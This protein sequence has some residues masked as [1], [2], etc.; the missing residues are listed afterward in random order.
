MESEETETGEPFERV[1]EAYDQLLVPALFGQWA[2]LVA[3]VAGVR[4]GDRVLDVACGTGILA[5][6][7]A[8]RVGPEGAVSA[9]DINPAMLAVATRL[10]PQGIDWQEGAAESLPYPDGQFDVVVSQFGLMLFPS[11]ENALEEMLRVLAPQGRLVVAVFDG[12]DN[13]PVYSAMADIYARLVA[14]SIGEALRSPFS[15]GNTETLAACFRQAGAGEV[16]IS[17]RE[18]IARFP[19]VRT[20]VLSDVRGWFPFAGIRLDEQ[21]IEDVIREATTAL[22]PYTVADGAVE[23]VLPAHFAITMKR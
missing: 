3:D 18:G 7:L 21:A 8:Q 9:L 5:R 12:L 2:P 6:T 1:A 4:E 16:D 13:L 10:G 14:E 23:F 22:A 20:M 19:D 15:L 11:A 17:T